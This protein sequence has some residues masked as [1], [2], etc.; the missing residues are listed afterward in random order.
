MADGFTV[1]ETR[2]GAQTATMRLALGEESGPF[3]NE[4]PQSSQVIAVFK[5][6]VDAQIGELTFRMRAGD[7]AIV[8]KGEPHRFVGASKEPAMTFNVYAPPAY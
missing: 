5:G 6:E 2:D 7:C 4:H 3:G 1:L 8:A